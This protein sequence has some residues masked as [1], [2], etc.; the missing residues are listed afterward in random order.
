MISQIGRIA[1]GG[2]NVMY[3]LLQI[4]TALVLVLAA[5]TAFN[6]FPILAS[7]LA[8]DGFVPHQFAFRGDRLA[9][10][11]G[12]F[13][14][15]GV[16]G[17]LLV[18]FNADT[19]RLI[20]LYAV[21]VFISFTLSQSGLVLRWWRMRPPGW[22]TTALINGTGA[23]ATGVVTIIVAGTKFTHG[24]WVVLIL[25]P[26]FALILRQIRRHYTSVSQALSLDPGQLT[27]EPLLLPPDRPIVVPIGGLNRASLRAIAYARGTSTNVTAVH[28]V[29]DEDDDTSEL[30]ERWQSLLPDVPL[31]ILESPYRSF[32]APFIAYIDALDIPRGMP[33]TVVV[34][35][36]A[37]QH[38]WQFFL[39]N[40]TA[41]RLL[42]TLR[43][44]P[45]TIV[46][47]VIQQLGK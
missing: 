22:R 42:A 17:A 36:F 39:H 37:A 40:Q 23:L 28:V 16:A 32:Q 41:L 1:F 19:H 45:N 46:V 30:E 3:Y 29:T 44:R 11:N 25:I 13:V 43:T 24:A 9:F 12:I 6:G 38:W 34:A 26:F 27:T 10:T 5:N 33:L 21:G 20:P 7:I 47:D 18:A 14:L 2:E 8:R 15:A 4:A 31:V 35:E